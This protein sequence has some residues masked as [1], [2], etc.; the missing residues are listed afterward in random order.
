M[1]FV[2]TSVAVVVVVDGRHRSNPHPVRSICIIHPFVCSPSA[3][4]PTGSAANVPRGIIRAIHAMFH[5]SCGATRCRY[6]SKRI[7]CA[8]FLRCDV[9]PCGK[10]RIFPG[11]RH[12]WKIAGLCRLV[13]PSSFVEECSLWNRGAGQEPEQ[14]QLPTCCCFARLGYPQRA[15]VFVKCSPRQP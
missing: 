12:R 3:A 13:S 14:P 7:S 8:Q 6:T 4:T 9:I 10:I 15:L 1:R 11:A 5:P 2:T